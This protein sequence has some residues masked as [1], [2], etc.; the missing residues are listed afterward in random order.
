MG[1]KEDQKR[2]EEKKKEAARKA[3]QKIADESTRNV[4]ARKKDISF[5]ENE[6]FGAPAPK[7]DE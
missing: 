3:R 7:Y 1:S 6:I 5:I 4:N 2:A